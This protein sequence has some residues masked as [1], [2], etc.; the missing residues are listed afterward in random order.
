MCSSDLAL[1]WLQGLRS[2]SEQ[3]IVSPQSSSTRVFIDAELELLGVEALGFLQFLNAAGVLSAGVRE[4]LLDRV[5]AV[6]QGPVSLDDF[7]LLVLLVFWSFGTE[8]DALI[9]DELFVDDGSR[10]IH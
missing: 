3:T 6:P 10:A 5:L 7:K 2:V 8:P 9:L 1:D 4:T